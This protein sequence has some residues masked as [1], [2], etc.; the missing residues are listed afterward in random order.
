MKTE[1]TRLEGKLRTCI[2]QSEDKQQEQLQDEL[3]RVDVIR[4]RFIRELVE[5]ELAPM[6]DQIQ[7]LTDQAADFASFSQRLDDLSEMQ[8][9]LVRTVDR[10]TLGESEEE[11][12]DQSSHGA[13]SASIPDMSRVPAG[14]ADLVASPLMRR[15][16][17]GEE[18]PL[19][20]EQPKFTI[21]KGQTGNPKMG[22]YT[23][24]ETPSILYHRGLEKDQVVQEQGVQQEEVV[25][26]QG[27]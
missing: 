12:D 1:L 10:L 25:A 11:D 2:Q 4:T 8:S 17:V 14:P 18:K 27:W 16:P 7:R 5:A 23:E 20:E 22:E 13:G 21:A 19:F 15:V 6:K 9:T 26:Q 3:K 24:E